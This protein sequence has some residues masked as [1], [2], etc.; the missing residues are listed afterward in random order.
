MEGNFY[1]LFTIKGKGKRESKIP[2][3]QSREAATML[4]KSERRRRRRMS[5]DNP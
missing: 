2:K 5:L 3:C 1:L 4:K